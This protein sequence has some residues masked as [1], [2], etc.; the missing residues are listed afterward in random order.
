MGRYVGLGCCKLASDD[1]MKSSVR[2]VIVDRDEI[3]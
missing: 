2:S 3:A 1:H